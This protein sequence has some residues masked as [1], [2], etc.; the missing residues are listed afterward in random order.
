MSGRPLGRRYGGESL[1][2][3]H[4]LSVVFIPYDFGAYCVDSSRSPQVNG[5]TDVMMVIAMVRP[6]RLFPSC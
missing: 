6:F 3:G 2:D 5:C 1:D 4:F